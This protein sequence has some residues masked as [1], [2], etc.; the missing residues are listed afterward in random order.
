MKG[1]EMGGSLDPGLRRDLI[2]AKAAVARHGIV[3]IRSIENDLAPAIVSEAR[4]SMAASPRKLSQM[5]EGEL[6]KYLLRLR[7]KAMRTSDDLAELYK[8]LLSRLGT[9]NMIDLQKDLEGIGQLYSWERIAKSVEEV[10]PILT[11]RGFGR[12]DLGDPSSLSEEFAIELQQK[13]PVAFGRFSKLAKE[14]SDE[15]Q[16]EDEV[17]E[18]P[19]KGKKPSKRGGAGG[20]PVRQ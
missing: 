10:N 20:G 14:A 16:R 19:P 1:V 15:L 8:R 6:D 3:L 12:I 2:E 9:D 5:T 4:D 13:W 7:K 17:A 11:E 18:R